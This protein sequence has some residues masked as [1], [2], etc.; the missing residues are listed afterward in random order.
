MRCLLCSWKEEALYQEFD[1]VR[2]AFP[3]QE[4]GAGKLFLTTK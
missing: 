2:L 1:S 3:G 4:E